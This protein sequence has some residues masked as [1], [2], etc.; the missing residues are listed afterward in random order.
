[1]K[2]GGLTDDPF[3]SRAG[4]RESHGSVRRAAVRSS[5]RADCEPQH[6][7]VCG[8]DLVQP[9]AWRQLDAST[10]AIGLRCPECETQREA[11]C[12]REDAHAFNVHLYERSEQL[13]VELARLEQFRNHQD[14][15]RAAAFAHALRDDLILPSDF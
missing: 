9:T 13:E 7:L 1:M 2:D 10:W 3:L 6:C 11:V 14:Q 5:C 4:E 15:R 12:G 8:S